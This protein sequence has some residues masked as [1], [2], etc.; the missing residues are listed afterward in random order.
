MNKE[1][2]TSKIQKISTK[3]EFWNEMEELKLVKINRKEP[4]DRFIP[5]KTEANLYNI[6]NTMELSPPNVSKKAK[7]VERSSNLNKELRKN[8]SLKI[9]QKKLGE[10]VLPE[11][12]KI[13]RSQ[14]KK[15][16]RFLKFGENNCKAQSVFDHS[17]FVEFLDPEIKEIP[18]IREIQNSPYKVLDA[19]GIE[20]NYYSQVLEWTKC[21]K[22]VVTLENCVYRWCPESQ[23]NGLIF[24]NNEKVTSITSNFDGKMAIGDKSGKV[25][26]VNINSCNENAVSLK[27]HQD[28]CVVLDFNHNILASGSRDSRV[29]L[30]DIR[31]PFEKPIILQ[32]H[33]NEVC[34]L[35][36]SPNGMYLASGGADCRVNVWDLR[37]NSRIFTSNKHISSVRALS[38]NPRNSNELASGGG[39]KDKT[40]KI[41]N[42]N[43]KNI[44]KDI[45][46]GS[47]VTS[48]IYS[49]NTE[50]LLS[51][52]GY[53]ENTITIWETSNYKKIAN[54][55][56]HTSRVLHVSLSPD[57]KYVVSAAGDQT[58]RFWDIFP[59]IDNFSSKKNSCFS[60]LGFPRYNLLR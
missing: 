40:I 49:E 32:G 15:F 47:Q 18:K 4:L 10:L 20:D 5:K 13:S 28:R 42:I 52:H 59:G 11:S 25:N 34:G 37:M 36:F 17:N 12:A 56:G 26:I 45:Y 21:N 23:R 58:I 14:K 22:I 50:E 30:N 53:S 43:T 33:F 31:C 2:S 60:D 1:I 27:G 29:L 7:Q 24:K 19:P 55:S 3:V 51:A 54:L 6:F 38:W 39:S 35:K 41:W 16:K 46:C 9:F 57:S 44:T 8:E 48:L